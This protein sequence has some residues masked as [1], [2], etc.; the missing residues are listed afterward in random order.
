MPDGRKSHYRPDMTNEPPP[1][2]DDSTTPGPTPGPT[3][4]GPDPSTTSGLPSYG[5]VQPPE[6]A[7]P[8]PPPPP[9]PAPSGSPAA[10]SAPAAIGWGWRK[11]SANAVPILLAAVALFAVTFLLGLI[12]SAFGQSGFGG[13]GFSLG[14]LLFSIIQNMVTIVIS[15]V[16]ARG[17]LDV[18][19]GAEFNLGAAFAKINFVNVI[20]AGIVV[21]VM[22]SIGFLLLVIPGI[23]ALFLTYFATFFVV[24]DDAESPM[25]AIGDSVKLVSSRVGD[26][27]LLALLNI[28]VLLAGVIALI[29]GLLVAYPVV[30]LATA[31]AY[32]TFRGRPVA[33]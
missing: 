19:D 26:S 32:R 2:P 17:A 8:P 3:P 23:V 15:A 1:F 30:V 24:D 20:I 14:G 22:V 29:V 16:V 4:D 11:F 10:F 25:K 21:S 6:G 12:G 7:V 5:S 9:P 31:Y 28:L 13:G 27:L 33:A 18:A